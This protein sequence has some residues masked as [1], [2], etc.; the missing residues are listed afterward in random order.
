[1][2]SRRRRLRKLESGVGNQRRWTLQ[3]ATQCGHQRLRTPKVTG[4]ANQIADVRI[5]NRVTEP[6]K[7]EV[8]H[9]QHSPMHRIVRSV[10][11]IKRATTRCIRSAIPQSYRISHAHANLDPTKPVRQIHALTTFNWELITVEAIHAKNL[12]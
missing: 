1:M 8:S 3:F 12:C 10:H 5:V 9:E 7:V 2:A 4:N 11:W 6:K